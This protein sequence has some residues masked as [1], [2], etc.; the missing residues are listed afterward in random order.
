MSEDLRQSVRR[1]YRETLRDPFFEYSFSK[2]MSDRAWTKIEILESE[3]RNYIINESEQVRDADA[4]VMNLLARCFGVGSNRNVIQRQFQD[5]T[6][7]IDE[8]HRQFL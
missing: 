5:R 3:A 8:S 6:Q 7:K 1:M 4:K 2:A